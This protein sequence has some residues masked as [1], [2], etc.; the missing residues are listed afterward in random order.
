MGP[1]FLSMLMG[2]LSIHILIRVSSRVYKYF[3]A[4][5]TVVTAN[6]IWPFENYTMSLFVI[7]IAAIFDICRAYMVEYA[8]DM[9]YG[10]LIS[11]TSR[12]ILRFERFILL[13]LG[14]LS[15]Q[16]FDDHVETINS[17]YER[18]EP[19][20]INAEKLFA[21][22]SYNKNSRKRPRRT[23]NRITTEELARLFHTDVERKNKERNTKKNDDVR[24]KDDKVKPDAHQKK[25]DAD[26]NHTY[27]KKS[28]ASRAINFTRRI[29]SLKDV[30]IVKKLPYDEL[31]K[32][33][34]AYS[35]KIIYD[36]DEH[37]KYNFDPT[38]QG[39]IT[40]RSLER[41]FKHSDARFAYK[42]VSQGIKDGLTYD[43]FRWHIRQINIERN[44]L[45]HSIDDAKRLMGI[46]SMLSAII[47]SVIIFSVSTFL[48]DYN[49]MYLRMPTPIML[50][51]ALT[52]LKDPLSAFIFIIYSH[53][54]DAGDRIIIKEDSHIVQNI[55][56][57]NTVFNK[58]NGECI[59]ISNKWLASHVTKN[60]K[61]S[62]IQKA[63]LFM[64][65]SSETSIEQI[66]ALRKKF[67]ELVI[68]NK[69][70]YKRI[71]C[72]IV[73]VENCNK[74][75]LIIYVAHT[76]NFQIGLYRWNR[77]TQF[78]RHL[79]QYL[80]ELEIEYVPMDLP[81]MI[82]GVNV[83]DEMFMDMYGIN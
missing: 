77:H 61:R 54:F 32:L 4:V 23:S 78:M 52:V 35:F 26:A 6:V 21:K 33:S 63:E 75:K 8:K 25:N 68:K 47:L 36:I 17:F 1:C 53:P 48:L 40:V 16:K 13:E 38:L 14:L 10:R 39:I 59:Y 50:F 62:Q 34:E 37:K 67:R 81:I 49:I 80:N 65:I 83:N 58:W 12:Q 15:M 79:I 7:A 3:S 64:I 31:S 55:N 18:G 70:D 51:S 42:V 69:R 43:N 56:V 5:S 19:K 57:Y 72:D 28:A 24:K 2:E 45:F 46:L 30:R 76:T 66:D 11:D 41:F 27:K 20:Q 74:M 29:S 71:T 9:Y 22:W 82:D 60:C 73:D 44:G